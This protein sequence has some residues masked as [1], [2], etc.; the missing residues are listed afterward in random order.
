[1]E[2]Y[3]NYLYPGCPRELSAKVDMYCF[4]LFKMVVTSLAVQTAANPS[5][6]A[7]AKRNYILNFVLFHLHSSTFKYR[8]L[9]ALVLDNASLYILGQR[10][11]KI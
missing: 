9:V 10:H 7:N 4:V 2:D 5:N 8:W 3:K 1:M 6:V 11:L